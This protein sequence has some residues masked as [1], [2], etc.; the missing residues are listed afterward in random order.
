MRFIYAGEVPICKIKDCGSPP[1]PSVNGHMS[2][3]STTFES[4]ILYFCNE[5]YYEGSVSNAITCT[6]EGILFTFLRKCT[7]FKK[8][9][10]VSLN[11][12]S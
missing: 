6:A 2:G 7:R 5:G 10:T 1:S 4:Q 12:N 11:V 8:M 9:L 3:T